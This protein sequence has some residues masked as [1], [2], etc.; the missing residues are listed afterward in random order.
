[1]LTH[2]ACI[3]RKAPDPKIEGSRVIQR[4]EVHDYFSPDKH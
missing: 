1:M 2:G 3:I 4:E